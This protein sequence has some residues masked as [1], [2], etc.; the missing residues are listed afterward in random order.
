[1]MQIFINDEAVT[2]QTQD[3]LLAVLER[4][5]KQQGI[6]LDDVAVAQGT[7]LIARSQWPTLKVTEDSRYSMFSAVAGG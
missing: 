5:A 2:V 1:M 3:N 6:L 7:I 4:Y